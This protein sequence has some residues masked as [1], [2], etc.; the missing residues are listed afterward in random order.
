MAEPKTRPTRASVASFLGTIR[1]SDRAEPLKALW[2]RASDATLF[3][4]LGG[5][6]ERGGTRSGHD[7]TGASCIAMQIHR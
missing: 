3:G 2:S 4:V 5:R 1:Q 6:G 7:S